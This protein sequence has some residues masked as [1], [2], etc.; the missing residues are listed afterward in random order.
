MIGLY[1]LTCLGIFTVYM[2]CDSSGP[3]D[4]VAIAFNPLRKHRNSKVIKEYFCET[5]RSNS[6]TSARNVV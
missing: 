1:N 4:F 2:L 3:C 6:R 5:L